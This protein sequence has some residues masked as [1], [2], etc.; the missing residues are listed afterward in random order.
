M[1]RSIKQASSYKWCAFGA[2]AV[3]TFASVVD[4]GS[5]SVALPLMA[6]YFDTV[7]PTA[8]WIVIG[9]ALA[10]SALL[11]PMGRLADLIGL[12][13]VYLLGSLVYIL[14]AIAAGASTNLT[15]LI[16][17]RLVQG[18]GAAMTQGTGMAIV[19]AA[20]PESERGKALGS[21]LS[22][23]G[24]G[25]IFG[26]AVGGFLVEALGW[27]SVFFANVP[28]VAIGIALGL[29]ILVNQV[30]KGETDRVAGFDWLGAALSTGALLILLL[31]ITNGHRAGWT[32][33]PILVATLVFM[34]LLGTFIWWERRC[35]SPMLELRF[36]QRPNFSFAVAAGFL[37]F[38][39]SS[40]ALFLTPFYLQ[41]VLDFSPREAGLVVVPGAIC[42]TFLGPISGRLSDRFGW[43][44]FTLGGLILT[45]T[46]LLVLSTLTPNSSLFLVMPALILLSCG[47]GIF[48]SPNVSAVLS[49][50]E[51]EKYG[52]VSAFLN[53]VRNAGNVASIA[54]ATAIVTTT[55]ASAGYQPSLEAVKAGDP[56]GV[57]RAFTAGLHNAYLAMAGLIFLAIVLSAFKFVAVDLADPVAETAPGD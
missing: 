36:F 29:A 20:F 49:A 34:I 10:I 22:I 37:I 30:E 12:K 16:L 41:R 19:I 48:Y 31:T 25:A 28:M 26:P 33:P 35:S 52:V 50:V 27:R 54:I 42:M 57:G 3:G 51:R 21:M 38:L 24:M 4:H 46:G 55:M 9:Y 7:I 44:R 45:V 11:L 53:L 18:G 6:D 47:M 17:S 5:V 43:R 40:A 32:S 15:V 23:V 8:Q 1:F 13:R 39:G 56:G 14:G 2:V